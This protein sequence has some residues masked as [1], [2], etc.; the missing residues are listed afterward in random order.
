LKR[1][2]KTLKKG[3]KTLKKEP[4][5]L[6]RR[7]GTVI[8]SALTLH[9]AKRDDYITTKSRTA[10]KALELHQPKSPQRSTLY[11]APEPHSLLEQAPQFP[12]SSPILEELFADWINSRPKPIKYKAGN[13]SSESWIENA[14]EACVLARERGSA[15]FERYALSQFIQ[16]CSMT[17]FEP[18]YYIEQNASPGTPLRRFS[19]H[20]IAWDSHF[21]GKRQPNQY[22]GLKATRNAWMVGPETRDPRTFDLAHWFHSCGNNLNSL[23][24]HHSINRQQKREAKQWENRARPPEWGGERELPRIN[25]LFP[26]RG[27]Q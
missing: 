4:K 21:S 17:F 22:T 11:T 13:Y 9:E 12:V 10:A 1:E 15:G 14:A 19:D 2:P 24:S 8:P 7:T 25:L 26:R 27:Y 20:W 3:P 18:W 16:N 6:K 23:C 5:T